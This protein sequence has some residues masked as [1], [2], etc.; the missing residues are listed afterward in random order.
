MLRVCDITGKK[1]NNANR[2]TFSNKHNAYWQY[3]NLQTKKFFSPKL[4]RTPRTA[5]VA[6][7][8]IRTIR[9]LGLDET[10]AKYGVDLA[11][12]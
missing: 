5:Q 6:T 11:K 3:P 2:V 12:F 7:S 8:T 4:D 10:A 9:K 1:A